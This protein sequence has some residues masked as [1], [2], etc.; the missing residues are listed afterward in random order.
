M[1]WLQNIKLCQESLSI[2]KD[3]ERWDSRYPVAS[4]IVNG[5]QIRQDIPN[6]SSIEASLNHYEVLPGIREFPMADLGSGSP[7]DNFYAANDIKQSREVA[8]QIKASREI[9]PLIIAIDHEGPYILE[10]VHRFVALHSIGIKS[11]P[12]LVVIDTEPQ[13]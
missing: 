1:N 3:I 10:G 9:A 7:H 5:L 11:F 13:L 4:D 8:S 12:A 6:I 2:D